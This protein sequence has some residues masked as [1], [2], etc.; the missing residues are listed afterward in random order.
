M[1]SCSTATSATTGAHGSRTPSCGRRSTRFRPASCGTCAARQRAA[2]VEFVRG[3]SVV[4]PA[5]RAATCAST[6]R[7]PSARFDPDVLTIGFARRVATYK[8]L[9]LLTRDPDW[10]IAAAGRRAARAGRAR[11]QGPPP[12]RGGQAVAAAAVRDEVAPGSSASGS[13]SSTTTTSPPRRWLVRGCDVWLNVPRPPLEA[14]GHERDEVGRQRRAPAQRARRL[15]GRG[16]RR[17]Q[18]LGTARRDRARP[19]GPGR[20]RCDR[21]PP[22]ARRRRSCRPS[23][24]ATTAGCRCG[25]SDMIAA[26]L[27]T[28]APRFSAARMLEEYLAGPYRRS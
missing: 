9:D 14:S 2:L 21:A 13:C 6:S 28:L 25:G 3:R 10:T 26:S 17:H 7:P 15:V 12:R 19:R 20:A 22:P 1:A 8:R 23:T 11:R 4:G 24:T 16:L 18:R 27:R 5:R